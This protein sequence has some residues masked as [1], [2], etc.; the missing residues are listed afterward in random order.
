MK[1][2][3]LNNSPFVILKNQN[4]KDIFYFY[5]LYFISINNKLA[6]W[7]K[8]SSAIL[9]SNNILSLHCSYW[10][11]RILFKKQNEKDVQLFFLKIKYLFI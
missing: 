8:I 9:T 2:L 7:I 5:L 4:Q 1:K 11:F 3:E 10:K 6:E